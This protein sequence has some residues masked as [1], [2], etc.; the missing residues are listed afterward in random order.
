MIAVVTTSE[1][2]TCQK[3]QHVQCALFYELPKSQNWFYLYSIQIVRSRSVSY[4]M[5]KYSMFTD[6]VCL[7]I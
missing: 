1:T 3:F 2:E 6:D 4:I 5:S 7:F